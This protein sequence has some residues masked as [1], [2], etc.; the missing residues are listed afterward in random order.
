[1]L[2]LSLRIPII[3]TSVLLS[4]LSL[5]VPLRAELILDP[6]LESAVR[7]HLGKQKGDLTTDDLASLRQMVAP[8]AGVRSYAG[9]EAATNLEIIDL[10]ENPLGS[11]ILPDEM[12]NLESLKLRRTWNMQHIELP[13]S[14]PKLVTLDLGGASMYAGN[15]CPL[16]FLQSLERFP[17]L[18]TLILRENSLFGRTR[19]ELPFLPHL[20]TLDLHYTGLEEISFPDGLANLQTLDLSENPIENL[21]LPEDLSGLVSL[22]VRA[23]LLNNFSFLGALPHLREFAGDA[24]GFPLPT[25]SAHHLT[26]LILNLE[27]P[28]QLKDLSFLASLPQLVTL[29]IHGLSPPIVMPSTGLASLEVLD[30]SWGQL[31]SLHLPPQ[32]TNI[33][34]LD[35]SGNPLEEIIL[36]PRLPQLEEFSLGSEFTTRAR[37]K[38]LV[39]PAGL[40]QLTSLRLGWLGLT[41]FSLGEGASR[42]ESLDLS[43][44]QLSDDSLLLPDNLPELRT[45]DLGG[46]KLQD[47]RI[48]EGMPKLETLRVAGNSLH[49]LRVPEGVERLS[50]SWNT[51]RNLEGGDSVLALEID[52]P[53][54]SFQPLPESL[55]GLTELRITIGTQWSE[56]LEFLS[57]LTALEHLSIN[58]KGVATAY[59]LP[60]GLQDL[61]ELELSGGVREF[62][63]GE[64]LESLETV[65]IHDSVLTDFDF[66]AD[67]PQLVF[68]G[69]QTFRA[70]DL[71][72]PPGLSSLQTLLLMAPKIREIIL[73]GD[74]SSLTELDLSHTNITHLTVPSGLDNLRKLRVR[75][76]YCN[77]ENGDSCR[78]PLEEVRFLGPLPRLEELDLPEHALTALDLPEVTS[79]LEIV[80]LSNNE[81]TGFTI[82]SSATGLTSLYLRSNRLKEL[83]VPAGLTKL[84]ILHVGSNLL[85]SL[86]LPEDLASLEILHVGSNVLQSLTLPEDL[87]SLEILSVGGNGL[88]EVILP[89]GL[90]SLTNLNLARNFL[91]SFELSVPVLRLSRLDLSGNSLAAFDLPAS[92]HS[93]TQ[94]YLQENALTGF[95]FTTLPLLQELDVSNNRLTAL[96]IPEELDGLR[97][98]YAAGNRISDISFLSVLPCLQFLDLSHNS[99]SAPAAVEGESMLQQ[100]FLGGNQLKDLAF[101]PQMP[102]LRSLS[103]S[104]NPFTEPIVVP[105]LPSLRSLL[106]GEPIVSIVLPPVL[107][108]AW[109]S[110]RLRLIHNHELEVP[111]VIVAKLPSNVR[112]SRTAD[113]EI[114]LSIDGAW[115]KFTIDSSS[116]LFNWI[117]E[118]SISVLSPL[119]GGE[120][121]VPLPKEAG[122]RYYRV[123]LSNK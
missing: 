18:E 42:L 53:L 21:S 97:S 107:G 83:S 113:S 78:P 19:F 13:R 3:L 91:D 123:R 28:T 114:V 25:D 55:K 16:P 106:V 59:T 10:S 92:H 104:G 115:G 85:Q 24:D 46:N 7:E 33:R 63:F 51:L 30:F 84:R 82:P 47:F 11:L 111:S 6:A 49:T 22:D 26:S 31:D 68:L 117:E 69:F 35:L 119:Q 52:N 1:M 103:I 67:A 109:E 34:V 60:A 70:G 96:K 105:E 50:V 120:V 61:E 41:S 65:R 118:D 76:P 14:A 79:R 89:K 12:P 29:R 62:A 102:V 9:M 44:N 108:E 100:L 81:L 23:T 95:D 99:L 4:L 32:A 88:T 112:L 27:D 39:L 15:L 101:L 73:P 45:L 71:R 72:L 54:T 74:L 75:I 37:L 64:S 20:R 48:P 94:L 116:D 8:N 57:D 58:A 87:A 36:P 80:N 17:Q 86:T 38:S 90:D 5:A 66:L 40:A 77:E 56:G 93:L 98:L 43:G 2:N 121:D 122:E 110:D